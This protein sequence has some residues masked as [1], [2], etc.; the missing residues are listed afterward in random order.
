LAAH[1][2]LTGTVL[3]I[4]PIAIS[5]MMAVVNPSYLAILIYHP[6]G[7]FL[8]A[9]AIVCLIAAHFLIRRIVDIKI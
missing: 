4:L 2:K 8:I 6:Y 7:K 5:G 1:G 3:T 9:G